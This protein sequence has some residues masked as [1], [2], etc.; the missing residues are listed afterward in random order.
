VPEISPIDADQSN[1]DD[2][3]GNILNNILEAFNHE[4]NYDNR[5]LL[6]TLIPENWSVT[7]IMDKFQAIKHIVLKSK[8]L[9]KERGYGSLPGPRKRRSGISSETITS[10]TEFYKS[11]DISRQLPGLNDCISVRDVNGNRVQKQKLLVLCSL[12]EAYKAFLEKYPSDNIGFSKFAELR[13]KECILA[14][15]AGTHNECV[16]IIHQNNNLLCPVITKIL[17]CD[18]VI[19]NERELLKRVSCENLTWDCCNGD[20]EDCNV[21]L[22]D[23]LK[24]I[25]AAADAEEMNKVTYSYLNPVENVFKLQKIISSVDE[26]VEILSESKYGLAVLRKHDFI[27]KQQSSYLKLVKNYL[28]VG[29]CVVVLDFAENYKFLTQN[30][31][32]AAHYYKQTS[33]FISNCGVLQISSRCNKHS[34]L[35]NN[36]RR[37]A[38]CSSCIWI[39]K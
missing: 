35:C 37:D 6:L 30:E 5:V 10:V 24:Q 18:P 8:N 28:Q 27:T 2:D 7:R 13:P 16:C 34:F 23:F 29:E 12:S 4:E 3:N 32:Q 25:K 39:S 33:N 22:D 19:K 21:L 1:L 9:I 14:G 36:I 38:R 17:Q 20:C 31:I 26:I 11:M 15:K